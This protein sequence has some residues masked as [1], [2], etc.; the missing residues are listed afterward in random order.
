MGLFENTV[1]GGNEAETRKKSAAG[2]N[3]HTRLDIP[4]DAS[5][6]ASALREI[7]CIGGV[8]EI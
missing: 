3:Q 4:K 6:R 8:K 5:V 7:R 2:R 1:H